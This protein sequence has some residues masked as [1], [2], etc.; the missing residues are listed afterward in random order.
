MTLKKE[1]NKNVIHSFKIFC[2]TYHQLLQQ[3][4]V[5]DRCS[6]DFF[7]DIPDYLQYNQ[8]YIDQN[9]TKDSI[10]G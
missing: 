7:L 4:L 6:D 1:I 2:H 8:I 9:L 3:E 10:L 5:E